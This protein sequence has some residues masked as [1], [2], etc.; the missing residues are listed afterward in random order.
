MFLTF[1]IR[2]HFILNR[3]EHV[4]GFINSRPKLRVSPERHEQRGS[5]RHYENMPRQYTAI[6]HGSKNEEN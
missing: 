5:G 4:K 1:I 6:I 3:V 2:K